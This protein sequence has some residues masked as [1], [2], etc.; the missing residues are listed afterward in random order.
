MAASTV[1]RAQ[2][3]APRAVGTPAEATVLHVAIARRTQATARPAA[4]TPAEAIVLHVVIAPRTQATARLAAGTPAASR[5]VVEA[6][7]VIMVA[8][9]VA[10]ARVAAVVAAAPME[11]EVAPADM[12]ASQRYLV[13]FLASWGF[14]DAGGEM[15]AR[16]YGKSAPVLGCHI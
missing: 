11:V 3:T 1:L 13:S 4:G 5:E 10:A 9:V 12:G 15:K 14:S 6:E 8:A 16:W 7:A 2:P